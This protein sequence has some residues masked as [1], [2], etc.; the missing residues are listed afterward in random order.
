MKKV[1][2]IAIEFT[3]TAVLMMGVI[4]LLV[5]FLQAIEF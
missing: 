3:T 1:F 4:H 2:K 5:L